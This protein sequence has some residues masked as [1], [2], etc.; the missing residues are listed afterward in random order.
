MTPSGTVGPGGPRRTV[1]DHFAVPPH[2]V[3]PGSRALDAFPAREAAA[4]ALVEATAAGH[5]WRRTPASPVT[6]PVRDCRSPV[7][8]SAPFPRRHV[9]STVR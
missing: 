8:A 4:L 6:C 7:S 3:P 1:A 2:R 5:S 9:G